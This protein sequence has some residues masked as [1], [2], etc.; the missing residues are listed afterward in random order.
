MSSKKNGA[1]KLPA[2]IEQFAI[3]NID[4]TDLSDII[5]ENLG[6]Q[7]MTA[8]ELDRAHI[9]TGGGQTWTI[10]TLEG[11]REEKEIDGVVIFKKTQRVYWA[12]E[13][14]GEGTPPDC[15]SQDG[16]VG[17]GSPGGACEVCV[18]NSWGSSTKG[19]ARGKA[20][21]EMTVVFVLRKEGI[22]PLVIILPPTSI[23]PFRK[24]MLRLASAGLSYSAVMTR[25]TLEKDKNADG[26]KFSKAVP[27]MLSQL[28]PAD[29]ARAKSYVAQFAPLFEAPVSVDQGEDDG[30][31]L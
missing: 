17:F 19:G 20:C 9:P 29:H 7:S 6:G 3:A 2:V 23:R 24:Y 13:F 18:L 16:A 4:P 5:R 10:P 28:S 31:D 11:E 1:E 8:F 15:S 30:I 26:I 12:Q 22:L 14:T 27:A 25:F 21:K